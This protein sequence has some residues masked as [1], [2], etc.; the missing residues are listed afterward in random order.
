MDFRILCNFFCTH[1]T[2]S[3]RAQDMTLHPLGLV[4]QLHKLDLFCFL[5]AQSSDNHKFASFLNTKDIEGCGAHP[6]VAL[7]LSPYLDLERAGARACLGELLV[8]SL[9]SVFHAC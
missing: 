1:K 4:A 9:L 6:G 5:A 3:A 7:V 2:F 8:L